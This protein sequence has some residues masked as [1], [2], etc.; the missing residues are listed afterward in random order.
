MATTFDKGNA[1]R[2][3]IIRVEKMLWPQPSTQL[4]TL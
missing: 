1:L 2:N 4:T 3:K